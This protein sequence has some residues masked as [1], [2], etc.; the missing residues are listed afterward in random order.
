[1]RL[2]GL[3]LG[4]LGVLQGLPITELNVSQTSLT[5]LRALAGLP[6]VTLDLGGC[7]VSD[8]TPLKGMKLRDVNIGSTAVADLSPLAGMPLERLEMSTSKVADLGPL[9][10]LRLK[11]LGADNLYELKELGPLEGMP[12]EKLSLAQTHTAD[13]RPLHGMLLRELDLRLNYE[14]ADLSPLADCLTLEKLS[15]DEASRA[16]LSVLAGLPKLKEIAVW[17]NGRRF[18]ASAPEAL[19]TYGFAVPEIKAARAAL[20]AVGFS[21]LELFRVHSGVDH[22]LSIEL[23][24]AQ[25]D[26]RFVR[27]LPIKELRVQT[28][29]NGDVSPLLECPTLQSFTILSKVKNIQ[30]LRGMPNLRFLKVTNVGDKPP[31]PVEEF[32]KAYDAEHAPAK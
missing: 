19:A 30:L 27:G 16:N 26:L 18:M 3:E 31:A 15:L 4:D 2:S 10:G 32:W 24:V 11:S 13:L 5:D 17:R 20:A 8:L 7:R 1:M 6:L 9:R 28:A 21:D 29:A 25:A 23:P 12:L 14:L 22:L